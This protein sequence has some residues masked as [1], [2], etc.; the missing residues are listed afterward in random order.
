MLCRQPIVLYSL[1]NCIIKLKYQ[2]IKFN[3]KGNKLYFNYGLLDYRQYNIIM[4]NEIIEII[5]VSV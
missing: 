4:S 1:L 2:K 3:H 5:V